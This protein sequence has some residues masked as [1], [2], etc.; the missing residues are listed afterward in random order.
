MTTSSFIDIAGLTNFRDVGGLP[1]GERHVRHGQ[2][3]R[4]DSPH[5]ATQEGIATMRSL[6]IVTVLDLRSTPECEAQPGPL[7]FEHHPIHDD[8][9]VP[10]IDPRAARGHGGGEQL[11]ADLYVQMLDLYG[12]R[13]GV[14]LTRLSEPARLPA[15]IHCAA[16]K[17]RTGL[18]IALLL[19]VLGVNRELVL[20]DYALE[21]SG[22]LHEA[23]LADVHRRFVELGIESDAVV[24]MLGTPRSAMA[25]AM[26][27][28][29]E[30]YGS[31][32]SYLT[33]PA[34]TTLETLAHLRLVLLD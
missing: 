29:D 12:P 25:T 4:S 15:L 27:H 14:L 5:L 9:E 13:Y 1:A 18:A 2:I 28:L 21:R 32:E 23:R 31:V 33:G 17:D 20:D 22:E 11:L 8:R 30:R 7:A 24:G 3:F 16:G 26:T 10:G 6:G 19:S 34:G